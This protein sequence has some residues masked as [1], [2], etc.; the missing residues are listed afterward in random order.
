MC[1]LFYSNHPKTRHPNTRFI[2][3]PD[4][5]HVQISNGIL[6]SLDPNHLKTRHFRTVVEW[7]GSTDTKKPFKNL[8]IQQPDNFGPFKNRTC[9]IFEWLLYIHKY[10]LN[11]IVYLNYKNTHCPS[12]LFQN[13]M[14]ALRQIEQIK[15]INT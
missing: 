8:T 13:Q 5:L 11:I 7:F 9:L 15:I 12:T 2:W 3:I 10:A 4:T 6:T 14:L 1:V